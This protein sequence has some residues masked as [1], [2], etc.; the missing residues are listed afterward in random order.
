METAIRDVLLVLSPQHRDWRNEI[1][2]VLVEDPTHGLAP[3]VSLETVLNGRAA[4]DRLLV[5]RRRYD[6]V[7]VDVQLAEGPG[8]PVGETGGLELCEQLRE[9]VA[10][11]L[12]LIVPQRTDALEARCTRLVAPP[13]LLTPGP[14]LP[15]RLAGM[16]ERRQGPLRR[17]NVIIYVR[18]GRAWDYELHGDHFAYRETGSLR[19]TSG[20]LLVAK[21]ISA[22]LHHH[23][24]KWGQSF[25][26]LGRSL[27]LEFCEQSETFDRHLRLGLQEAGGAEHSRVTFVVERTHFQLAFEALALPEYER[28]PLHWMVRAPLFRNVAGAATMSCALFG[29]NRAPLNA[30]VV[31]AD[32]SGYVDSRVD[33]D[34]N[35]LGL[36]ALSKVKHEC[37]TVARVCRG[38]AGTQPVNVE[39]LPGPG[40]ARLDADELMRRLAQGW[41][42]VHFAGHS[43]YRHDEGQEDRGTLFVGDAD[44]PVALDMAELA[45]YLRKTKLLYLSSCESGNAAF[46]VAAANAG[47]PALVGYRWPVDDRYACMHAHLFYRSLFMHR[48]IET[49]FHHTRRVMHRRLRRNPIWAS[50]MLVL[51]AR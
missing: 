19:V 45:P 44:Q 39:E 36:A 40:R 13:A 46:A 14:E 48:S 21:D 20:M 16:L 4:L 28:E 31:R 25:S 18:D 23:G 49:A 37:E 42:I 7:V 6:L 5:Q 27:I 3:S 41:D 2:D 22:S 12:A 9:H 35:A 10:V 11:P 8:R 33:R 29:S 30:L 24:E 17:L 43:I 1:E 34:G 51:G 38:A 26:N 15:L 47:V 32:V 50:S